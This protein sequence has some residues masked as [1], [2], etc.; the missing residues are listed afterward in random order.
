MERGVRIHELGKGFP[1]H[2]RIISAAKRVDSVSK[3]MSHIKLLGCWC[4]IIVLNVHAPSDEETDDM[5][6]SCSE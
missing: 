2:K 5:K 4:G 3:K 1:V 6:N